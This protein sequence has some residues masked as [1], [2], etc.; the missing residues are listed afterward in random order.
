MTKSGTH[1][2]QQTLKRKPQVRVT[3]HN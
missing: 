2:L 1:I 3:V